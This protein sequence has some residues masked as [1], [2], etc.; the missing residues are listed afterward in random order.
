MIAEAVRPAGS[1]AESQ[2]NLKGG[3][4]GAS[5]IARMSGRDVPNQRIPL[6][7]KATAES[8]GGP[9]TTRAILSWIQTHL[10]ER[11]VE[12]PR[13]CAE[14]LVGH[15]LGCER[16]RLY[17]EAERVL[18][19]GERG[20]LRELVLRAGKHEPVQYLVGRWPFR[21][22]E[23]EV[24]SS[25]LIPRPATETLVERAT[26]WYL[27]TMR[28][29]PL[30]MADIGTG[31]GIIA[32]SVIAELVSA[33]RMKVCAPL[34]GKVPKA[35]T[36]A[37]P[38]IQV[39][40]PSQ[41]SQPSPTDPPQVSLRCL[42]TDLSPEAV[43]LAKRNVATHGLQHAIDVRAGSLFDPFKGS[44]PNSFDLIASNPP[45]ISDAEWTKV[46]RNVRDYEPESSL[47]GG[48][49]GLDVI[50]P[51][52]AHAPHWL[53]SG[54]LLL[55]EIGYEQ[56]DAVRALVN[57]LATWTDVEVVRDFEELPRVL[58]AVRR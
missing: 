47:R 44:K 10:A 24:G 23:F 19:E 20:T 26:S 56:G 28:G 3:L 46:E 58:M 35:A 22:R 15:V 55:V 54:G 41:S 11:G 32:I 14:I 42:A 36:D 7:A 8:A 12:S 33:L 52:V 38:E 4:R 30:R 49:D 17:M 6:A 1:R 27:S 18:S 50:R 5:T 34:G 9:W 21:G 39:G 45:Y 13:L 43:Q 37:L 48:R 29:Q 25:T 31:T 2:L 51:L 57:N 16:I 53:R 40:A